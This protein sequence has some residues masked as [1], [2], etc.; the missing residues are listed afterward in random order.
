MERWQD[1]PL[2]DTAGLSGRNLCLYLEEGAHTLRLACESESLYVRSLSLFPGTT[3][4]SD[5]EKAASY[6]Q[7][8]YQSVEGFL[9]IYQ[10]EKTLEKSDVVLYPT[11]DRIPVRLGCADL[12]VFVRLAGYHMQR[13]FPH[14]RLDHRITS[15][16]YR[17]KT[18]RISSGYPSR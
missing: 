3:V 10:A 16:R 13:V 14:C 7:N 18:L 6:Q 4:S 15:F 1:R 8:G 5:A 12:A 17:R 2:L 9:K 11:Y